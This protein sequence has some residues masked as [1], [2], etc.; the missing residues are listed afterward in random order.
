[1]T[2]AK[3]AIGGIKALEG[4]I[5]KRAALIQSGKLA[6]TLVKGFD[7]GEIEA[8][9]TATGQVM[10]AYDSYS[11]SNARNPKLLVIDSPFPGTS[12]GVELSAFISGGVITIQ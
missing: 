12:C 6:G 5:N 10:N 8:V 1:M 4:L 3:G 2:S 9:K 7:G 11:N